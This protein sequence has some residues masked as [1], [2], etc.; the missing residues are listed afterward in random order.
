M[1]NALALIL[2]IQ[3]P[4]S[5]RELAERGRAEQERFAREGGQWTVTFEMPDTMVHVYAVQKGDRSRYRIEIARGGQK[6]DLGELIIR[7]DRWY[8]AQGERREIYRPFEAVF[9]F[10]AAYVFLLNA[11]LSWVSDAKM[12]SAAKHEGTER[13]RSTYR[14]P[15]PEQWRARCLNVVYSIEDLLEKTSDPKE[16]ERL[17][18]F[19]RKVRGF[20]V[21]GLSMVVD[22]SSGRIVEEGIPERRASVR[23]FVSGKDIP[24]KTFDVAGRKWTDLTSDPTKD[25]TDDLAMFVHSGMWRH[26]MPS[27]DVD[28]VL[29]N[30][31]DGGVRRIPYQ[32]TNCMP[33]CFLQGRRKVVVSGANEE[34]LLQLVEVDLVTGANRALGGDKLAGGH[35]LFPALSPDSKRLAA[36]H[37]DGSA[38]LL[39]FRVAVVDLDSGGA[40]FVGQAMDCAYV[41]WHPDGNSLILLRREKKHEIVR[42]DL[43]GDV[44]VVRTGDNPVVLGQSRRILYEDREQWW[45]CSLDGTDVRALGDGLKGF[46]F[47][48]P[49][50][51]G[52]RILMMKKRDGGSPIPYLV[53][54]ESGKASFVFDHPGLW[55]MPAWR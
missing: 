31:K 48:T 49:G 3:E 25:G 34:G 36:V 8:L 22:A 18:E 47:P 35:T 21:K 52:K 43:K 29:A 45:T 24:D 2:A 23:E 28:G 9:A 41:S 38:G 4:P 37:A 50:P 32:G 27:R 44:A 26:G 30:L 11:E 14:F 17:E 1:L 19:S 42:M 10:P 15:L 54:L 5:P 53:D 46:V 39:K 20:L 55:S 13:G 7:G 6:A 12:L 40:E 33:G 51:D 16:K